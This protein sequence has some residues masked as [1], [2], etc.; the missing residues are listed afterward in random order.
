MP[1][2]NIQNN[3]LHLLT[4]EDNG[5]FPILETAKSIPNPAYLGTL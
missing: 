4:Q 2:F 3:Y 1:L 5:V